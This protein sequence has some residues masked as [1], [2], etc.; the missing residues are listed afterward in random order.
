KDNRATTQKLVEKG[1]KLD[2]LQQELSKQVQFLQMKEVELQDVKFK[3]Q[4]RFDDLQTKT[5]EVQNLRGDLQKKTKFLEQKNVSVSALTEEL[6]K[7]KEEHSKQ[8]QNLTEE[9]RAALESAKL[10][11]NSQRQQNRSWHVIEV[12]NLRHSL[13]QAKQTLDEKVKECDSLKQQEKQLKEKCSELEK[14]EETHVKGI[15]R[16]KQQKDE[17]SS[18]VLSDR[19]LLSPLDPVAARQRSDVSK[20]HEE[21]GRQHGL[22]KRLLTSLSSQEAESEASRETGQ[23]RAQDREQCYQQFEALAGV[24]DSN[25]E[26][27]CELLDAIRH[28]KQVDIVVRNPPIEEVSSDPDTVDNLMTADDVSPY[29]VTHDSVAVHSTSSRNTDEMDDIPVARVTPFSMSIVESTATPMETEAQSS[30]V[31]S[32]GGF[33]TNQQGTSAFFLSIPAKPEL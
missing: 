14:V 6:A 33:D 16:L 3:S 7:V 12:S 11:Y 32:A 20:A 24:I 5:Q 17:Q 31:Q 28:G 22:M 15:N 9:Y 23:D 4:R 10:K 26:Q 8:V 29:G 2:R 21:L 19:A 1:E 13:K 27:I 30:S 25:K 18:Q